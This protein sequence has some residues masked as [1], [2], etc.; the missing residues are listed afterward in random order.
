[1]NAAGESVM[2]SDLFRGRCLSQAKEG[3]RSLMNVCH[4]A[5]CAI[6]GGFRDGYSRTGLVFDLHLI[7]HCRQCCF[8]DGW[9][10]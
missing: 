8:L 10:T 1:M 5:H 2:G 7:L 3:I 4:Y 9:G 6:G